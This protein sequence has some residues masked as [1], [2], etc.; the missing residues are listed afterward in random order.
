MG[1]ALRAAVIGVIASGVAGFAQVPA[2]VQG[3]R[4]EV[5]SVKP[6]KASDPHGTIVVQPGGRYV[7]VNVAIR[8]LITQ[9]YGVQSNQLVDG[10]DW[11]RTDRFDVTAKADGDLLLASAT[12]GAT[13]LQLML[14]ALL[15]ERFRLR[16][17][18]ESRPLPIYA[19]V[20]ARG[21][22][23]LG[24]KMRVSTA[25]CASQTPARGVPAPGPPSFSDPVTCGVRMGHGRL[26][27]A[28]AT[29]AQLAT[30]LSNTVQRVVRDNTGLTGRYSM[31][32]SWVPESMPTA[33]AGSSAV[34]AV[35]PNGT[36]IFT[37]L[38]EQLGLKL[39]P[40]RGPV[41]VVVIDSIERPTPD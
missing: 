23:A 10:P 30:G 9:A 38:Q 22:R 11:T 13:S 14:R 29:M 15:A 28:D 5:A 35:D 25:D 1:E 33:A 32:M 7:A 26:L 36:S 27:A 6:S 24:P 2:P 37:A 3:P 19:L 34:A 8:Q 40:A 41:D 17:H 31:E 16:V 4:F 18:Q 39:E 21:D 20:L 12:E